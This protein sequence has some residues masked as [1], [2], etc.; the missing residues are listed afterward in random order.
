MLNKHA[1]IHEFVNSIFSILIGSS[2]VL[3]VSQSYQLSAGAAAAH[4]LRYFIILVRAARSIFTL[5]HIITKVF[6]FSLTSLIL[7]VKVFLFFF[8]LRDGSLNSI[9]F[10]LVFV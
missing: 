1:N 3:F 6:F 10:Y 9:N 7:F 5:L 2:I 4:P 8:L